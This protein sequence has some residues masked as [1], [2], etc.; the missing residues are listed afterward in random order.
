MLPVH[1][2]QKRRNAFHG[3]SVVCE[4]DNNRQKLAY[5]L[6][7]VPFMTLEQFF[8]CGKLNSYTWPRIE[9]TGGLI[10]KRQETD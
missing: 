9:T 7:Y 6:H 10:L 5:I 8:C 2:Q 1:N 4:K 3:I